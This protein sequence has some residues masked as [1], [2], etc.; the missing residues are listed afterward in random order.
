MRS[1]SGGISPNEKS[2]GM[3]LD[4][5]R[6]ADRLEQAD[7]QAAD[8]LAEVAVATP[9]PRAPAATAS[10]PGDL[11]GD[12]VVV[13]GRLQRDVDARLRAELA[14]PH[15]GAVDDVLGL[16]VAVRRCARR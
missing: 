15:A 6:R 10:M 12:Q 2:S 8:L 5:P 9:G 16:D 3:P 4:L 7:H 14:R 13:L 1:Q 11:L